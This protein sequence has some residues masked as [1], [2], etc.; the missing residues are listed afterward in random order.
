[1]P[2]TSIYYVNNE[3]E[4]VIAEETGECSYLHKYDIPAFYGNMLLG[5]MYE[6]G[7]VQEVKILANRIML[8]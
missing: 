6:N 8:G 3:T 7:N 2:E 4:K 5:C 1:M